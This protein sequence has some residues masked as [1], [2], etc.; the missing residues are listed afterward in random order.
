MPASR[1]AYWAAKFAR[2]QVRDRQNRR[3][4]Q[5]LGWRVLVI[6]E[7]QTPLRKRA[8]LQRKLSAFLDDE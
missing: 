1:I 3:A 6:W 8:W 4:L 5:R 7:C 2:N